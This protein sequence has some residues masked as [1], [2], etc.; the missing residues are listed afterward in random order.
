[1]YFTPARSN[2]LQVDL[3]T[4][5]SEV[6]FFKMIRW[7]T[8]SLP[9]IFDKA[10]WTV[11]DSNTTVKSAAVGR[12]KREYSYTHKHATVTLLHSLPPG[13]RVV[14]QCILG[15]DLDREACNYARVKNGSPHP[16]LFL[17]KGKRT[18]Q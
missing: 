6:R 1:M 14:L 10:Q 16:I 13:E 12:Y 4:P 9:V 11:I 18:K 17:H 2:E 5:E 7:C 3:D 15:S 8:E